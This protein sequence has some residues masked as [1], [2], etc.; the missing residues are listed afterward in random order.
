MQIK[1]TNVD[2]SHTQTEMDK[3][4]L[5]HLPKDLV[6]SLIKNVHMDSQFGILG[7]HESQ[8]PPKSSDLQ[9]KMNEAIDSGLKKFV[10]RHNLFASLNNIGFK[11]VKLDPSLERPQPLSTERS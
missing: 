2:R 8:P 6:E 3:F 4:F 11:G 5:T 10:V 7:N 9:E 1:E